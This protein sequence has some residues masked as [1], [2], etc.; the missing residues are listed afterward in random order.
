MKEF[1]KDN[2][3]SFAKGNRN[4][5]VTVLVGYAQHLGID[6]ATLKTELATQIKKDSFIGEEI[7]R[8]WG[9]CKTNKY[10]DFWKTSDAKKQYKF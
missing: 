5:T 6:E 9:Y 1:I 8:L 3:L 2:S 10:K 7:S 4:S